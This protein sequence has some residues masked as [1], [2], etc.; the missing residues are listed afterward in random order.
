M[1]GVIPLL[2]CG[3]AYAFIKSQSQGSDEPSEVE[4]E[5]EAPAPNPEEPIPMPGLT[6]LKLTWPVVAD[7]GINGRITQGYTPPTH[8]GVDICIPGH[9]QDA[10]ATVVAVAPGTVSKAYQYA[11]GW[12]VLL[13]HG[14]WASG[15]LHMSELD[16]AI[17]VGAFVAAGQALGPMGADPLDGEHIVHLH[18]QLAVNGQTVDPAPHLGGTA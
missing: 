9:Y 17:E 6:D 8:M 10:K 7:D 18:I 3:A 16:P 11:R 12:A 15:Y 2:A 4:G 14:D 1:P 5:P 13:N